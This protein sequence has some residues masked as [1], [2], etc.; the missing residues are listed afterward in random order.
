MKIFR[1]CR[2]SGLLVAQVRVIFDL[3]PQ[4]GQI[5]K[6]L[7]YIEW[8][9]PLGM[10]DNVTGMFTVQRST[11]GHCP[12]AE[13]VTVDWIVRSCHLIGKCG[14]NI[15]KTWLKDN[16]LEKANSFWVNH[17]IHTDMFIISSFYK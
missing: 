2:F 12:N 14:R 17:Y 4:F 6:P 13:I 1:P 10:P 11:C 9:T 15:D 16:V 3:P 7:A 5:D 8:F